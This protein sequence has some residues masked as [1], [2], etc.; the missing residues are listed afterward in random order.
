M[1]RVAWLIL[2]AVLAWAPARA[3]AQSKRTKDLV[4]RK[5]AFEGN[6]VIEDPTLAASISTTNS[7]FFATHGFLRWTGLGEKR[8][9]DELNFQRDVLRLQVLYK[10]SGYPDVQIDT[11]VRRTPEDVYITFKIDEGT[12][13]VV[14]NF[15]VNGLDSLPP[16]PRQNLLVDLPLVEGDPFNRFAL[17]STIDT[18]TR[19]L[20]DRGYPSAD[21]FREFQSNERTRSATVTLDVQPG[22]RAVIGA[23]RVEGTQ[24]VAPGV[25]RD[26]LI[27]QPGRRFSQEELFQSQRNLYRS[28]LF[29]FASVEIDSSAF[30]V[31]DD[32]VPLIVRVSEARPLRFRG[33]LGYGTTDCF[34][35]G[36]GATAR[37]FL[38]NGRILDITTRVSKVGVGRPAN[39]G[40]DQDICS[41]SRSDSVGSRLL[42]Y[43]LTASLRRPAFI[44]PQNTIALSVFAERRSEYK[45]F[46]R[47]E[48]G[49]SINLTR[50]TPRRRLPLSLAYTLS[51]GRTEA[52]D[53]N[54]CAFFNAC[55]PAIID[56]L[57]Q[58]R[59]LATLTGTATLPRTNSPIDPTRGYLASFQVTHSSAIIGSSSLQRFTRLIGDAAWYRPVSRDVVLSWRLRGGIIFAP[60]ANIAGVTSASSFVPPEQR[61]YAGG[62]NDVRGFERNELGPVVY[63]VPKAHVDS[64]TPRGLPINPDSVRVSATGG[65]TLAVGNIELRFPS[66]IFGSRFRLAAFLDAGALWQRGPANSSSPARIRLT[67]GVGLRITTPL[68]PARLDVAYNA[69]D[70]Q[71]GPLFQT[72]TSGELTA[73]PGQD[74]YVLDRARNLTLHLAVGQAF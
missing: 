41:A 9:F 69:Y 44:S 52:T 51:Y 61:F 48:I 63:V 65:N 54:F 73:V 60:R 37:D 39:W 72:S 49:T 35:G 16:K 25:V 46:L 28:D 42:N 6:K 29:R 47:E 34:R 11:L 56:L 45:V 24:G 30:E 10:R 12:P 33:G 18:I 5:L 26:F 40:L 14:T 59:R 23:I 8:Y 53:V 57:E 21:V 1:S 31:G 15:D 27:S 55:T 70:L 22:A 13:V 43:N 36:L 7:G 67:P 4:V 19:R 62:P 3:A 32:S 2:A 71:T 50:E 66:P 20:R 17:Q 68:G 74:R 38:G 64:V 58:R